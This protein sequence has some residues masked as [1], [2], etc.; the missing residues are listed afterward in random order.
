MLLCVSPLAAR[1]ALLALVAFAPSASASASEQRF[2]LT[3]FAYMSDHKVALAK[4]DDWEDPRTPGERRVIA[5]V[6]TGP[7]TRGGA[8]IVPLATHTWGT[9]V[10]ARAVV[11]L[12][13]RFA[14]DSS[15]R[16][17]GQS[18]VAELSFASTGPPELRDGVAVFEVVSPAPLPR[19][20]ATLEGEVR[21]TLVAR[22]RS[23]PVG[24]SRHT[25]LVTAGTPR[26]AASWPSHNAFTAFRL[27]GAARVAVGS[28]TANATA[29]RAWRLMM[30]H[31]DLGADRD[32][33][34]WSL[35]A[36]GTSG[37]CMT[38]A[39]FVE[40]VVNALGFEG[41]RIVYVYPSFRR[42]EDPAAIAIPHPRLPGAFTIE[43]PQYDIRGQFRSVV[44]AHSP[45]QARRHAGT[46]GIER[47]KFRDWQGELHNY[48]TAFV[49]D[50]GGVRSY[51]GGGYSAGPYHAA[52]AFLACACQTVVWAYEQGNDEAWETECDEPGPVFAWATGARRMR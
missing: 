32:V 21:W 45:A 37:Q 8:A 48:A 19:A 34:P 25:M 38:T 4:A 7:A 22:G 17:A 49:I 14:L 9:T 51:Y 11:L 15:A 47:L 42:P 1:T 46:H 40:A 26:P 28:T 6:F 18:N 39:A 27:R 43:S 12:G 41:G 23:F 20:I 29:E 16:L 30:S 13:P 10:H 44:R 33:N 50:E 36:E 2:E 52:D 31:Y 3:G 24:R 35:L 5:T